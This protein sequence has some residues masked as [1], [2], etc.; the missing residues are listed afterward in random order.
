MN[1]STLRATLAEIESQF[2]DMPIQIY[3]VKP[4]YEGNMYDELLEAKNV[5][6]DTEDGNLV[7]IVT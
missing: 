7:C 3:L 5:T 6:V 2:G 1:I 4:E